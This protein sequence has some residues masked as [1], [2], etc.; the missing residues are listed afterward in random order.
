MVSYS[1]QIVL[2]LC[3]SKVKSLTAI[4]RLT[5]FSS[6]KYNTFLEIEVGKNYCKGGVAQGEGLKQL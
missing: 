5:S 2:F 4:A 3:L 6:F 1:G